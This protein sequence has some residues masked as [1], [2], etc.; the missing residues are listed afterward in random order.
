MSEQATEREVMDYD[1]IIVG[2]GPAGLACADD[3]ALTG[4][5]L[6]VFDAQ[7][8]AGGML[9]LGVPEYRLPRDIVQA[10]IQ[11]IVKL[12]VEIRYNARLGRDFNLGDL[13]RD[14]F[15]AVFLAIGAYQSRELGI[16]GVQSDGVLRAIDFLLNVNLG[17]RVE[18]GRKVVVIGGGNVAFDVARSLIRDEG[19][20]SNMPEAAI[21]PA[22]PLPTDASAALRASEAEVPQDVRLA[23]DAARAAV[24]RGA[25]DVHMYCLEN[26]DEIPAEA[27]EMDEAVR[28]GIQMHMRWGP[29]RILS[30][31]GKVTGIELVQCSHVFDEAHR[32][33]PAFIEGSE[34]I[35]PCDTVVMAIGQSPDLSWVRPADGLT[36]TPRGMLQVDS[37]TLATSRPDVFAGGDLAFGPRIIITAVAEGKRAAQSIATF[38]TGHVPED[39]RTIRTTIIGSHHMPRDYEKLARRTAPTIPVPRRIGISEVEHAYARPDA[40]QQAERCLKC[41]INPVFDGDT[42]I[43]CG[44]CADVCPESCLRLVDVRDI[45]GSQDIG[46]VVVARYGQ[47]PQRGTQGAIIKDETACIRCGLCAVRCPTGAITMEQVERIPA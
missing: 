24:R 35:V 37:T 31:D 26:G 10:E 45:E 34:V 42:C 5:S 30:Q 9:V 40:D 19:L 28:E 3:L 14:G 4:F 47:L 27:E 46:A 21:E 20:G 11:S 6:T 15:E 17:Y 12:G 38:L 44:G 1:V 32:F 33:N 13:K 43:L 18:F 8:V 36:L 41:H 2:A 23:L 39:H 29:K 25:P 22:L 16:E 7:G